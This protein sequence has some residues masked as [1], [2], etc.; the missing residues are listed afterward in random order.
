MAATDFSNLPIVYIT[1]RIIDLFFSLSILLLA[2]PLMLLIA[3]ALWILHQENPLFFQ[4][5]I[6]LHSKP[7]T[8]IKFKTK[9]PKRNEHNSA[10]IR[11]FKGLHL[12][13]L[14]QLFNVLAGSMSVVGPRPHIQE[15]VELYE[16]WQRKRLS[17]K[18]GLTCLRQLQTPDVKI[19]YNQLVEYDIQYV[20]RQSI[21]LDLKVIWQTFTAFAKLL[22][23]KK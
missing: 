4:Q 14:P 21:G 2:L 16:P 5:R 7:F 9:S 18:P 6:G 19:N 10:T 13:E 17:V 20:E 22:F 11:W 12:D 1:K 23:Q 15:H 8:I 3:L